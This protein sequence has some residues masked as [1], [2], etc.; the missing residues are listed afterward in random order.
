M[1]LVKLPNGS[2]GIRFS[3]Q[4]RPPHGGI[5]SLRT[6][7]GHKVTSKKEAEEAT[8][9]LKKNY[10]QLKIEALD[11]SRRVTLKQ[12]SDDYT[13][14]ER[15]D[16]STAQ[17]AMDR[18]AIKTLGNSCGLQRAVKAISK[19]DLVKMKND[20]ITRGNAAPTIAT[21][22]RHLKAAFNWAVE[23]GYRNNP[24]RFPKVKVKKSLP[25]TIK[26]TDL[27]LILDWAKEHDYEAWRYAK[28]AVST[29]CRQDE[30]VTLTW[31]NVTLYKKKDKNDL[32]GFAVVTGKGDKERTVYLTADAIAAFGPE[33]DIGLVFCG[34]A[35]D[36]V[37]HHFKAAVRKAGLEK[38]YFHMLRHTAGASMVEAGM[39]IRIIQTIFGHVDIKTTLL[40]THV[41]DKAAQNE[42]GKL[43]K[44]RRKE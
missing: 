24:P 37:S 19:A 9:A 16:L 30:L 22:F 7:L 21:Y 15:A 25:K 44:F 27:D 41:N 28:A 5:V 4:E 6:I 2:Y 33:Q 31:Q 10:L 18:L 14:G 40:Y 43:A 20:C 26:Q 8:K 42:M 32:Y 34:W 17:I 11:G 39:D 38:P 13:T 29:G 1:N 36:T 35:G 23:N 12:F 3:R